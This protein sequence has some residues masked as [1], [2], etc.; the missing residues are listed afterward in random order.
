MNK[1]PKSWTTVTPFSKAL[2]LSMLIVFPILGFLLGMKYQKEMLTTV[3]CVYSAFWEPARG[4]MFQQWG[5]HMKKG[6]VWII[7][8]L[9][10]ELIFKGYA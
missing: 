9:V 5:G 10:V 6:L 7:P 1:L 8:I 2:A 4:G 3:D